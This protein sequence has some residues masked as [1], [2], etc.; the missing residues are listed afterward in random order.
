MIHDQS[1]Y[2]NFLII[3]IKI[4]SSYDLISINDGKM[5]IINYIRKKKREEE[6]EIILYFIVL[7]FYILILEGSIV[8]SFTY[9]LQ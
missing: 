2:L 9:Q 7:I 1:W 5:R 8:C 6:K 4:I 3:K